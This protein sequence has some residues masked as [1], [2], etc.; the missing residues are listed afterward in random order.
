MIGLN[1]W[2]PFLAGGAARLTTSRPM[3]VLVGFALLAACAPAR[4]P[5]SEQGSLANPSSASTPRRAL[6]M[7]LTREPTSIEPA[8]Q[9]MNREWSAMASAFLAYFSP[10]TQSAVPYLAEELP[11]LE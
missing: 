5:A 2:K 10:E 11:T 8:F 3:I 9:P 4:S 7:A 1:G 6:S